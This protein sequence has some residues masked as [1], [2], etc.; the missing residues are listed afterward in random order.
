MRLAV[1]LVGVVFSLGENGVARTLQE[2]VRRRKRKLLRNAFLG[3]GLK[4]FGKNGLG[5]CATPQRHGDANIYLYLNHM[6]CD[7]S[8]MSPHVLAPDDDMMIVM[9]AVI[10]RKKGQKAGYRLCASVPNKLAASNFSVHGKRPIYPPRGE[11]SPT[12]SI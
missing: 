6:A 12:W 11:A 3:D 10:L 5:V 9:V 8:V 1:R 7:W 4:W 2:E